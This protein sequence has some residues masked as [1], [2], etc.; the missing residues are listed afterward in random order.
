MQFGINFKLRTKSLKNYKEIMFEFFDEIRCIK[1]QTENV[2]KKN[3]VFC[4]ELKTQNK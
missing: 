2:T 4:I 3:S 1:S